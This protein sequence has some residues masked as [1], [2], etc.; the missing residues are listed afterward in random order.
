MDHLSK[1]DESSRLE[2]LFKVFN[3]SVALKFGRRISQASV[4]V[5]TQALNNLVQK[6]NAKL[7]ELPLATRTELAETLGLLYYFKH[8]SVMQIFQ[9]SK[10]DFASAKT[11]FTTGVFNLVDEAD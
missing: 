10:L 3:T 1:V 9:K 8:A 11:A 2:L 7:L 5:I 6:Q 4:I